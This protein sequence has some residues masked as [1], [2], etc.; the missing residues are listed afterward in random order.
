MYTDINKKVLFEKEL[1]N[2]ME[3]EDLQSKSNA[4]FTFTEPSGGCVTGDNCTEY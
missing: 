3:T 1:H 4:N 2:M